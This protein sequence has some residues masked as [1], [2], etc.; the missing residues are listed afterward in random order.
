MNAKFLQH[1]AKVIGLMHRE[2]F[3]VMVIVVVVVTQK[4]Y[5]T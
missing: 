4:I 5:V 2:S 3:R 1:I